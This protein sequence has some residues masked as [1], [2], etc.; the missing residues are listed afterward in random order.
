[1]EGF[2]NGLKNVGLLIARLGVGGILLIHGWQHWQAGVSRLVETYTAVGAPYPEVGA[3]ATIIFELVGGIF[4]I[5]GAL[6][7]FVGRRHRDAVG[8][9]HL[10]SQL[11]LRSGAPSPDGTYNGGY[12]YDVA[13]GLLGLLFFVFGAGAIS[14]DRLFKRKKP[15]TEEEDLDAPPVLTVPSRP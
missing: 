7:R 13:L 15:V 11:Q 5:V 9:E 1:M 3:W 12:E 4:L 14:I 6:T 10:L 2:R 8:A